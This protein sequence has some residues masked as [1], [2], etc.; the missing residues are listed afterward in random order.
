MIYYILAVE[1]GMT[2]IKFRHEHSNNIL[3]ALHSSIVD[4]CQQCDI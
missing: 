4:H 3:I 1:P 2:S